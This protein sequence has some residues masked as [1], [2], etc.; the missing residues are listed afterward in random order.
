MSSLAVSARTLSPAVLR[1]P[2]PLLPVA[3]T[4]EFGAEPGGGGSIG[5]A[6]VGRIRP[7][8]HLHSSPPLDE[9]LEMLTEVLG[10]P[11]EAGDA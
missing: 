9:E 11:E 5:V 8:G 10:M 4:M 3:G 6:M 2:L 7:A 1:L